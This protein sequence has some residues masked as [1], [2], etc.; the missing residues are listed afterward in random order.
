MNSS[1]ESSTELD[2]RL[3]DLESAFP[4]NI[5]HDPHFASPIVRYFAHPLFGLSGGVDLGR[6]EVAYTAIDRCVQDGDSLLFGAVVVVHEAPSPKAQDGETFSCFSIWTRLYGSSLL[7][8][9]NKSFAASQDYAERD[10]YSMMHQS[11]ANQRMQKMK[12]GKNAAAKQ[13]SVDLSSYAPQPGLTAEADQ[14]TLTVTWEGENGTGLKIHFGIQ[15]STPII[16]SLAVEKKKG[17]WA[18]LG[19]NLIPEYTVVSGKRRISEQQLNPL[20][21]L[22]V[23]ITPD[24]I[25]REKWNTF[26]DAPLE[27]PGDSSVSLGLPR[28][29]SEIQRGTSNFNAKSCKVTTRGARLEVSFPGLTLGIFSGSLQFTIYRGTNLIRQEAI[30]KT[31]EPSVAY[32]Y[33]GGLKGFGIEEGTQVIWQ[34]TGG[35]RQKYEFGGSPNDHPVALRARNRLA[36]MECAQG[37]IAVFPPPHKFFFAREIEINL[38]YVWYRKDDDRSFSIGVRHGDRE[39]MFRPYGVSEELREKRIKQA[40]RFSMCH[41]ALYNAPPGTWQ[42][43]A[44]YYYPCAESAEAARQAA[45]S[46]THGD[47]YKTLPGYKTM[48]SHYHTHYTEMLA[49][50]GSLDVQA[51]WIPAFKSLGIDIALMSDFHGDGHP[52][53]PGA[54]RLKDLADYFAAC[55]RHSDKDFL[56]LPGE[57]PSVHFGGH[58]TV[59]FPK[60]VYWTRVRETDQPFIEESPSYGQ[61]YHAGTAEDVLEMLRREKALAWQTHPYTKGSTGYPDAVRESTHFHSER[62]LGGT[63]KSLPVDQSTK[64]LGE[65]L[66]LRPLDNMNNSSGPKYVVGEV[67]TYTKYPEDELYPDSIVNY[68]KVSRLPRFDEDWSPIT[69]ALRQGQFF[70]TTGEILIRDYSVMAAGGAEGGFEVTADVEWTFPLEF[71]E[72]V[73]GDGE[74]TGNLEI[75]GIDLPPFGSHRF[76]IPFDGKGKKWIRFA[77]WDT[78]GNG[79]I[80]QPVHLGSIG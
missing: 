19:K 76:V 35:N 56:I 44:L 64:R 23:E 32:K 34:D 14:E 3:N 69:E 20:R 8:E 62:F 80:C 47:R 18:L 29:K 2:C 68:V 52:R 12:K 70:V 33:S 41:F 21:D 25:E 48:V 66:S 57:E 5:S 42:R 9:I 54:V 74:T 77:A 40:R 75:S 38:G 51:P 37:S 27:I 30:V 4:T 7:T 73:W 36:I 65:A 59:F 55:H 53:D 15:S 61:V 43:M 71:V 24:L 22:G 26:W 17:E 11:I 28:H 13:L 1:S 50:A 60:P 58:Y 63:F 49:D 16:C 45:L 79:A 67:D 78:A 46:F 39:E 6:I 10:F 31:E 72:I